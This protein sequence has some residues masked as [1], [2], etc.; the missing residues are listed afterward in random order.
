Q[1]F[2]RDQRV[3]KLAGLTRELAVYGRM[4]NQRGLFITPKMMRECYHQNQRLLQGARALVAVVAF[5]G[6]GARDAA[7]SAVTAWRAEDLTSAQLAQRFES[8]GAR[9]GKVVLITESENDRKK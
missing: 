3:R 7:A 6:S 9:D 2:E 8:R 1:T 5:S 4:Q